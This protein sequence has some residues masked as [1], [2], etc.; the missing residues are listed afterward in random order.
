MCVRER[1]CLCLLSIN[2]DFN[3]KDLTDW[4]LSGWLTN[5]N[6]NPHAKVNFLSSSCRREHKVFL[7]YFFSLFRIEFV[8]WRIFNFFLSCL[9]RRR[10]RRLHRLQ[11]RMRHRKY[12]RRHNEL[13]KIELHTRA[14]I[15]D[16]VQS[17]RNAK[18]THVNLIECAWVGAGW[19]TS[20]GDE[21]NGCEPI[22]STRMQTHS[23]LDAN[24]LEKFCSFWGDRI[25]FQA[26]ATSKA[27][28][29][30][31]IR[32]FILPGKWRVGEKVRQRMATL[33]A[34]IKLYGRRK[35]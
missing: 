25:T 29:P 24:P 2:L 4:L 1:G 3:M 17:T 26:Y 16:T 5:G 11:M 33:E 8:R 19:R 30:S 28:L 14:Q 22:Q 27:Y 34:N 23:M 31:L 7:R 12:A 15:A 32:H 21:P 35:W 10:R 9:L 13:I 18:R 20:D 6:G